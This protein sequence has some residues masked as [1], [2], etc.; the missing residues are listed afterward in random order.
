MQP[1]TIQEAVWLLLAG[2]RGR[3]K[4]V[5]SLLGVDASTVSRWAHGDAPVSIEVIESVERLLGVY[6]V[7][8][9]LTARAGGAAKA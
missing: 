1:E 6:V 9:F 5:A 2:E 7:T 3:E 8:E 4:Q